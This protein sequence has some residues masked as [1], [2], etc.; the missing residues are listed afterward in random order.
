QGRAQRVKYDLRSPSLS[1][2][3]Q[4]HL[5]TA[6]SRRDRLS[7]LTRR[8]PGLEIGRLG[9]RAQVEPFDY[10]VQKNSHRP[11]TRQVVTKQG[12]RA[13]G[14]VDVI[15]ENRWIWLVREC[16]PALQGGVGID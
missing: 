8:H 10:F 2:L 15:F 9:Q 11:T 5:M 12:R 14:R 16:G 7:H 3:R 1:G 4:R 13:R 6:C